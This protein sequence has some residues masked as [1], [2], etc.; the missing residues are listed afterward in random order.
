MRY[1]LVSKALCQGLRQNIHQ[2]IRQ[3]AHG[4]ASI[5]CARKASSSSPRRLL[6]E[7]RCPTYDPKAFYPARVGETLAG[8]YELVSKLGWGSGSTVWL[9]RVNSWLPHAQD[10][11]VALKIT[12]STPAIRAAAQ[13]ELDASEHMQRV[14]TTHPGRDHVRLVLDAFEVDGPHGSHTCLA[15]EPLRQPLWTLSQPLGHMAPRTIKKVMPSILKTLDF[16]HNECHL[17]HTDLKGDHFM[18][19]FENQ[20]VLD[21][22]VQRQYAFPAQCQERNG[23]PV[24]ETR[25]KFG[26]FRG[27]LNSVKMTDFGLAVRGDAAHLYTHNI[28]PREYAAPEVMLRAGWTYPADIWNLGLV[29]WELLADVN[30]LSGRASRNAQFCNLTRF[31]QMIRLMGP[32]PAELLARADR[33]TLSNF[34]NEQGVFKYPELVPG[35]HFTFEN[36]TPIAD[37]QDKELFIKFAKRMLT[38]VPEERATARQLLD[39][40]WL[41]VSG[42]RQTEGFGILEDTRLC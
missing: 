39:D 13:R 34:F 5:A 33:K 27:Q 3:N 32:P 37:S 12:N 36:L 30:L 26:P 10:T 19:P 40:P 6:E 18:V 21:E 20:C 7:E 17:I 4:V 38:W 42:S 16:L 1:S 9:A 22:Y 15:F 23:R 31:A 2:N 41:T 25:T 11:Y 35:E 8:R 14:L 24:Y 29:I 28:Q